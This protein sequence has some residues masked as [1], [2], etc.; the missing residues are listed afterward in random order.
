MDAPG[1]AEF[2]QPLE[3]AVL[4]VPTEGIDDLHLPFP[5]DVDAAV[6]PLHAP[7]RRH[8][9]AAELQVD[10]DTAELPFGSRSRVQQPVLD[11]TAVLPLLDA[12][13]VEQQDGSGGRLGA[14]RRR[15]AQHLLQKEFNAVGPPVEGVGVAGEDTVPDGA[16]EVGTGEFEPFAVN[17]VEGGP[18]VLLR[19]APNV[20]DGALVPAGPRKA[21]RKDHP[22][23]FVVPQ[24]NHLNTDGEAGA[25]I[26]GVLP[27]N[28]E[29]ASRVGRIREQGEFGRQADGARSLESRP[30]GH[31]NQGEQEAAHG[32]QKSGY[33]SQ[34]MNSLARS[35]SS[36]GVRSSWWVAMHQVL[37]AGSWTKALR[38]P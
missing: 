29:V 5:L 37:P 34:C 9:G 28:L 25:H 16:P 23:E 7:R 19:L 14:Q 26:A 33:S 38:S 20:G 4:V 12:R 2:G 32:R 27:L 3:L 36:S 11:Q 24:G 10:P 17:A 15:S 21:P 8:E 6:A 35:A 1:P 13:T 22:L 30:N 31:E 18:S